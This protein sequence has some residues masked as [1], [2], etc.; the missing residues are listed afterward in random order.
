M[1][2]RLACIRSSNEMN[3]SP[4]ITFGIIV[5]NGEPFTEYCLKAIYPFAHE[6]IVVEGASINAAAVA[7]TDGHSTDGTLDRL[8][9]FKDQKDPE[10]KVQIITRSG[11][12]SEKDEQSQA[13]ADRAT[14]DY[15]WQIDIDE[16][17]KPDDMKKIITMLADD[18]SISGVSFYWKNFWGG[19][20]YMVDG[21]EYRRRIK[22]M[23][24]IRRVFRW[25]QGYR[26]LSHR[27]PTVIDEN[28]RDLCTLNW[29][30]PDKTEEMGIF[31]YHYGMVFIKQA[32]QKSVYY[33]KMW[34]NH[35]DMEKWLHESFFDLSRPFRILH[36]T[37]PPSWLTRFDGDH[38]NEVVELIDD[39]EKGTITLERRRTDD[40]E[41]LLNSKAY[42]LALR[43]LDAVYYGLSPLVDVLQLLRK[44]SS[45]RLLRSF[46]SLRKE[47][48]GL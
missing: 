11:F 44:V 48:L 22:A 40:I 23:K 7:T 35:K 21:W 29:I 6:I 33:S 24:G 41:L 43:V 5:L 19:F 39:L 17:Y 36:G 12:W 37:K 25:G 34:K 28:G 32:L 38:P 14:G 27:P 1:S 2:T 30:G 4:R 8:Y 31:C 15:L 20:E 42:R 13:Y 9:Q 26:Y 10:S 45:W 3:E 47:L 46:R 18:P 16:F